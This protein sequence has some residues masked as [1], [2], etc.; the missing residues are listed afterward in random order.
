MQ[1]VDERSGKTIVFVKWAGEPT[2]K[3]QWIPADDLTPQTSFDW[4]RQLESHYPLCWSNNYLPVIPITL[5][6]LIWDCSSV[7]TDQ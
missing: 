6:W 7:S 3:S 2:T 4:S 1:A 5:I